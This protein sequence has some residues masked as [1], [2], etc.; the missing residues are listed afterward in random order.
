MIKLAK[1][2]YLI[3]IVC[4]SIFN[5]YSMDNKNDNCKK[6]VKYNMPENIETEEVIDYSVNC[7]YINN[8]KQQNNNDSIINYQT[9][10]GNVCN[11]EKNVENDDEIIE[12][13]DL[14]K[15]IDTP[16]KRYSSGMQVKLGFSIATAIIPDILIIDEVLAV[17]DAAFQRKC[18][19][20]MEG[21]KNDPTRTLLIVGHNIRQLERIC[22]RMLLMDHGR[23]IA[24]DKPSMISSLFY[25]KTTDSRPNKSITNNTAGNDEDIGE[26]NISLQHLNVE[27]GISDNE[28]LVISTDDPVHIQIKIQAQHKVNDVE[29]NIGL[30][31]PEL[32][33]LSKSSSRMISRVFDLIPG[34]NIINV[35]LPPTRYAPGIYGVGIGI[36]DRLRR[37]I[38]SSTGMIW[39]Q[40]NVGD[41][42]FTDLP[43]GTL[44]YSDAEWN[45]T[46]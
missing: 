28:Y 3:N 20:R 23:L 18:I 12:F 31:N 36:Y 11:T 40:I 24:D 2:I 38:F 25:Q 44:T 46:T 41:R 39:L 6:S 19:D 16:I 9:Y 22:D 33:F 30:H 29:I 26:V 45:I 7:Y 15:F 1:V 43:Q 34:L 32:I 10:C 5:G 27:K 4:K 17:G 35:I 14:G 13:S 37:S 8:E 42:I 21:I